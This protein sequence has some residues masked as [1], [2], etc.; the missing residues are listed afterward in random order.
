MKRFTIL[1]IFLISILLLSQE[2]KTDSSIL[3]YEWGCFKDNL[4]G[5]V[6]FTGKGEYEGINLIWMKCT[7]GQEWNK[8]NND[9]TGVGKANIQSKNGAKKF[10][11]CSQ[12]DD[13]C[14]DNEGVLNGNGVSEVHNSCNGLNK[15][16]KSGFAGIKDWRAPSMEELR[17]LI[18]CKNKKMPEMHRTCGSG[19]YTQPAINSFFPNTVSSEYWT[20]ASSTNGSYAWNINFKSGNTSDDI[21]T[22]RYYVRCVASF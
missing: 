16:S 3:C 8:K 13:S 11:F 22:I 5:T 6:N 18:D 10:Q 2:T 17:V 19:N 15:I 4:N 21:M 9:C 14:I 12:S 7:Q 1:I 20:A